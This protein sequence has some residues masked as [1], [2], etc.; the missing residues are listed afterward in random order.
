M[1]KMWLSQKDFDYI[2]RRVPRL[3]V[4]LIIK[5]EKGILLTKRIIPPAKGKWHVP[6]GTVY[7]EETLEQAAKRIAKSELNVE[8]E[9]IKDIGFMEFPV[10]EEIY[11]KPVSIAFLVKIVSGEIKGSAQAMEI[12]FFEKLPENM[13]VDHKR[14]L[15]EKL[16]FE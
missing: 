7:I 3:C 11:G 9:I 12:E 4:D 10:K 2:Y 8:I 16:G 5:N 15:L 1:N 14:F 6:G 13:M